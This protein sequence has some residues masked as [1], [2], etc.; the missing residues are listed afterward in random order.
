MLG[1]LKGDKEIWGKKTM[2]TGGKGQSKTP[3]GW[4]KMRFFIKKTKKKK[5]QK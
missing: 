1:N 3:K 4:I 2:K 5:G